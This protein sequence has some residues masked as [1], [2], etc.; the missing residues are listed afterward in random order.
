MQAHFKS[1]LCLLNK[2]DFTIL[3]FPHID[4]ILPA[5]CAKTAG[6]L[7][8]PAVP[9]SVIRN[10]QA[11]VAAKLRIIAAASARVSELFGRSFPSLPL[12]IFF[13]TAHFIA[14]VA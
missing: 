2:I 10:Y 3:Y 4:N 6:I 13:A 8:I 9:V 5:T 11:T 12:I 7:S 14:V 1:S